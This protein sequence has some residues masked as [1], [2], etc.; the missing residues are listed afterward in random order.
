[1]TS[2]IKEMYLMY[3]NNRQIQLDNIDAR[4]KATSPK[5]IREFYGDYVTDMVLKMA[6]VVDDDNVPNIYHE[7]TGRTE[8]Y[9]KRTLMQVLVQQTAKE[10]ETK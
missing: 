5:P 9:N 3:E 7:L 4:D 10:L 2:V 6:N 8:Y 1:M